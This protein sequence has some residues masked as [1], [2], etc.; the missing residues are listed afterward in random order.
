MAMVR[1]GYSDDTS[2]RALGVEPPRST[3]YDQCISVYTT[4]GHDRGVYILSESCWVDTLA[5]P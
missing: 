1:E 2:P 4:A 5:L 3:R